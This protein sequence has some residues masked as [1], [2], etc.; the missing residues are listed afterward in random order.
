MKNELKLE[1]AI[2]RSYSM[3]L[4]KAQ[5]L[6]NSNKSYLQ[7]TVPIISSS[8]LEND[9]TGSKPGKLC[10]TPEQNFDRVQRYFLK[11]ERF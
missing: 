8:S 11:W 4:L 2:I 1:I 9:S 5:P 10:R 3:C 6:Y 7:S